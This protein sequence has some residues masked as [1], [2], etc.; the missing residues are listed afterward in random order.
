MKLL[1]NN[2]R[3]RI[4]ARFSRQYTLPVICINC[5]AKYLHREVLGK[6]AFSG[7]CIRCKC[8][9]RLRPYNEGWNNI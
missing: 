5:S 2:W 1:F 6:D 3:Y 8:S 4:L 7:T 9:E